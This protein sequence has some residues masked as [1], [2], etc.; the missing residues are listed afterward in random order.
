MINPRYRIRVEV[1][2]LA[3]KTQVNNRSFVGVWRVHFL[4]RT[5]SHF[6]GPVLDG[7]N[8]GALYTQSG[9]G[10]VAPTHITLGGAYDA[11]GAPIFI[12]DVLRIAQSAD[13]EPA[14]AIVE[15][16]ETTP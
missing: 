14:I 2:D 13:S 4:Y 3:V 6:T 16:I 1:V 7:V 12:D 11:S 9:P 8:L 10:T 5:G 15:I